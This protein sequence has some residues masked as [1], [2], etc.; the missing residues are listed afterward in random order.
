MLIYLFSLCYT[1]GFMI[2][3]PEHIPFFDGLVL[4][5]SHMVTVIVWY[6]TIKALVFGFVCYGVVYFSKNG[7]QEAI[8]QYNKMMVWRK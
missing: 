7:E 5:L 2:G 3:Y 1:V 8:D 4:W 6:Q